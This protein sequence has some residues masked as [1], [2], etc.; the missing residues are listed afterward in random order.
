MRKP[1]GLSNGTS[2]WAVYEVGQNLE[3]QFIEHAAQLWE[4]EAAE[5]SVADGVFRYDGHSLTFKELA[6]KLGDS[7]SPIMAS[8][9]VQPKGSD[10]ACATH[11]VDVEID[12]ETGEVQILCYTAV[13]DVGKAIHPGYVAGQIQGGAARA[14]AAP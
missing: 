1:Q 7:G 9:T 11:I 13:Q 10:P 3:R 14:W 6:A 8:A 4:V 2:T 12:P 5:V